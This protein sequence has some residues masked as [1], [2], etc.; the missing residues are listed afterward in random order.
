MVTISQPMQTTIAAPITISG[1]GL[2]SGSYITATLHPAAC[3]HGIR[4]HRIDVEGRNPVVEAVIANAVQ[5]PLCTRIENEAGIRVNTIEH[6][7]AAFHGLGIDN[8]R[9]DVDGPELPI[10]DGSAA[11]IVERIRRGGV[12]L[13]EKPRRTIVVKERIE[14]TSPSGATAVLEPADALELDVL[15]DFDDPA[16]GTQTL[17]YVH[18]D[19]EFMTSLASARTFCLYRD[20]ETM[21][22]AG[23]AQGGSLENAIVVDNGSVMNPEGLRMADEFVRHKAL[24]CL[25]DLYLLGATLRGKLSVNRPGHALSTALLQALMARPDAFEIVDWAAAALL[26]SNWQKPEAAAAARIS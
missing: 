21:R 16:I 22:Q 4:F 9:I 20:V 17:N 8:I 10:L 23:L 25:G 7:M 12:Q 5:T 19:G 14:V 1:V 2:H 13:Q 18:D 11:Q 24:D 26:G 3:D 6:F 15:I